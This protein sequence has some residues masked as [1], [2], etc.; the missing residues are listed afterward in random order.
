[1]LFSFSSV[2]MFLAVGL[3]VLAIALVLS[4]LLQPAG[5]DATDKYIPYECG[6]V[7]EGSAWIRFNI[8]FYVCALIFIIFDVEIIF[9]LP[10]AVV[11]KTLGPFA[12]VEGLIFI[13]ILAIGLAYVWKKGDLAWIKP[14]DVSDMKR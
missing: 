5:K 4:R 11:F 14:E 12:F 6:E 1:M 9:L 7:P 8:R 10:W 3:V 2:L 13:G